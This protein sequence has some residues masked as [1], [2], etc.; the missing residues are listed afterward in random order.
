MRSN[1]EFRISFLNPED[2]EGMMGIYR[3]W[4]GAKYYIGSTKNSSNR[5]RGHER[6]VNRCFQNIETGR[7][8]YY[9]IIKYLCMNMDVT[10]GYMEM[11]E[12]VESVQQLVHA[13]QVWLD[14]C[15]DDSNFLNDKLISIRFE[16]GERKIFVDKAL[17]SYPNRIGAC[18]FRFWYGEKYVIVK[19]KSFIGGI[20]CVESGFRALSK[21][22]RDEWPEDHLYTHLFDY[23]IANPDQELEVDLIIESQNPYRL[24]V[25]EQKEL[26]LCQK[27]P[28]CL[29][30]TVD[31]YVPVYNEDTQLFGWINKGYVLAFYRWKKRFLPHLVSDVH[32]SDVV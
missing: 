18:V 32:S 2:D 5:R 12:E 10:E 14:E 9:N 8:S 4:Y 13:E 27:D 3:I 7:G 28:N 21:K 26:M 20:V 31:A 25:I 23:M 15:K 16:P 11:I 29:N 17:E 30:N 24:L 1:E 22:P 19:S 6:E